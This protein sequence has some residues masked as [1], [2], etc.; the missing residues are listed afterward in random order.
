MNTALTTLIASATLLSPTAQASSNHCQP[1][2]LNEDVSFPMRSQ[3]RGQQ[4][5][6]FIDVTIGEQGEPA[7]VRVI[8]SSGYRLLDRAAARSALERWTFDVSACERKD[9]PITQRIAVEYRN[10]EY[11]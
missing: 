6:V 1:R 7:G 2:I 11:R 5:T 8:E 10:D 4:G 3:L 9:L